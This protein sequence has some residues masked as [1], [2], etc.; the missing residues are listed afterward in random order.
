MKKN[1]VPLEFLDT[2]CSYDLNL[3]ITIAKGLIVN[4]TNVCKNTLISPYMH[5]FEVTGSISYTDNGICR[6]PTGV[7]N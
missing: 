7:L 1:L 6:H 2:K 5:I 3:Y 4:I